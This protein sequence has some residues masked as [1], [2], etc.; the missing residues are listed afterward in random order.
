MKKN[1]KIR[2]ILSME[3]IFYPCGLGMH[4]RT[5]NY[6]IYNELPTFLNLNIVK[7][8]EEYVKKLIYFSYFDKKHVVLFDDG[9]TDFT[10]LQAVW[11]VNNLYNFHSDIKKVIVN[12][13]KKNSN[14][15]NVTFSNYI[16][17][18]SCNQKDVY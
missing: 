8:E 5:I 15:D 7:S 11:I 1:K 14:A 10:N 12:Q 9:F 3:G 6:L 18:Y 17:W 16:D 4:A 13:S 2:G